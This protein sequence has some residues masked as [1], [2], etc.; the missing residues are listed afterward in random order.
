MNEWNFIKVPLG[1]KSYL[2]D[3]L[4]FLFRMKEG[5]L[6]VDAGLNTDHSFMV[7]SEGVERLGYKLSDIKSL[8]LTHYHLDH[9]GISLRLKKLLSIPVYLH[10]KDR[11]IFQFFKENIERYPEKTWEFFRSYGVQEDVLSFITNEL[12]KYKKLLLGPTDTLNINDGDLFEIE[13]GFL[14]I[15]HTPGHSPGHISIFYPEKRILFG[16]DLILKDEL[17]HA[18]IYPHT[19]QYNPIKDYLESLE[20][21][22]KLKP[23]IIIPS[24]GEP[25]LDPLKRIEEVISFI[26]QK[27]DEVYDII[28]KGPVDLSHVC[29]KAFRRCEKSLSYFFFLSLSLSYVRYL[30]EEGLAEEIKKGDLILFKST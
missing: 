23:E 26:K 19:V 7:I 9:C 11:K 25:I 29:E 15:I 17:P 14:R 30:I 18:G 1:D 10:E 6:M 22:K 20:K 24:H 5:L 28:K 3:V 12:Q 27:I 21:I 8:I 4:V 2:Q 16:G 13:S